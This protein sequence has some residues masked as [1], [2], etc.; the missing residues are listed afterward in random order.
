MSNSRLACRPRMPSG[1]KCPA[2]VPHQSCSCAIPISINPSLLAAP[3]RRDREL[4]GCCAAGEPRAIGDQ[5][6]G[7]EPGAAARPGV[8]RTR[9]PAA[10][11]DRSE[12]SGCCGCAAGW[13]AGGR[14]EGT[15]VGAA[16]GLEAELGLAVDVL[17]PTAR[18][19]AALEDFA[20]E[21]AAVTLR[22]RIEALGGVA[23]LVEHGVCRI[24]VIGPLADGCAN[25][26]RRAIG[27][28]RLHRCRRGGAGTCNPG[29]LPARWSPAPAA[30][31]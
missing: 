8:V 19:V 28:V 22:L 16:A 26:Q 17:F 18:L 5:L 24:G 1:L 29:R 31:C 21:F 9:Q 12:T 2:F 7:R 27:T 14:T 30:C 4:L 10:S 13:A 25:P 20:R 6:Y 23:E 15:R 11:A 3:S